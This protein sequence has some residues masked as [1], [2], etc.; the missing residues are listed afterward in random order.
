MS[1]LI[2][3]GHYIIVFYFCLVYYGFMTPHILIPQ[4]LAILYTAYKQIYPFNEYPLPPAS[5]IKFVITKT[6]ARYGRFDS[7][8]MAIEISSKSCGHYNTVLAVL[9]HEMVHLALYVT[10][11]DG[12]NRHGSA[13]LKLKHQYAHMYSLDPKAI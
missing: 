9:L 12:W 11:T 3:W 4:N 6:N 5:K 7:T 1:R 10:K 13:F 2:G 8:N